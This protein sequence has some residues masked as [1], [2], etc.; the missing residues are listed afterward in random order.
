MTE[1]EPGVCLRIP[2]SEMCRSLVTVAG[3]EGVVGVGGQELVSSSMT[4]TLPTTLSSLV[5]VAVVA[6]SW[7]GISKT[8]LSRCHSFVCRPS[9]PFAAPA[10]SAAYSAC[11]A[12][13]RGGEHMATAGDALPPCTCQ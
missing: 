1:N 11:S 4:G 13:G 12:T 9:D 2:D 7:V 6:R 5:A 3:L 10:P 8:M